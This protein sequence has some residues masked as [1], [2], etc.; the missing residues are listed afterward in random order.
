MSHASLLGRDGVDEAVTVNQRALVEK[1]LA[2]YSGENTL[3]RELLQN[4]DDASA[5]TVE[6]HFRTVKS[7]SLADSPSYTS[8]MLPNLLKA[9]VT[10]IV[11]RNDGIV[12][13]EEDWHRLKKIAEGNPNEDKVRLPAGCHKH[14]HSR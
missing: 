3:Y 2:R 1:I 10:Q 13:R 12:F 9:P 8:Q 7:I 14:N 6:L 11:V 5:T 4:A